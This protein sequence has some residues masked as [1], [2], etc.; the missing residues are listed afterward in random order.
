MNLAI[1]DWLSNLWI[2]N[3]FEKFDATIW[4]GFRLVKI[5]QASKMLFV[6]AFLGAPLDADFWFLLSWGTSGVLLDKQWSKVQNY[7]GKQVQ[8]ENVAMTS[9]EMDG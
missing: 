4:K 8:G 5:Q 6:Y 7:A 3:E 1:F 2:I 9:R